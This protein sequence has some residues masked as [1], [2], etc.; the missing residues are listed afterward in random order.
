[1][2]LGI[3][4]PPVSGHIN[5]FAALG[6][7]L[8]RR[9]HRVTWFHMED[10]AERIASEDL[11]FCPIGQ[12][13]HP[14]G[15]LPRSLAQLGRLQGWPALRFTINAIRRT[16]DMI[17]RDL[18]DAV[19]RT[20]IDAL[21]V[22]QTEP[23][24]GSVAEHL[25]MPFLTVCNALALNRDPF[26]PPPFTPWGYSQSGWARVRNAM[27]YAISDR[28]MS[29]VTRVLGGY[30]EQWKLPLLRVGDEACSKLA[31]ISQQ[32]AAFDFPRERLPENF[33]YTGPLR[34]AKPRR[35][36]FPWERLDGRP[37]IFASL[38]T[39][40]NGKEAIFR[41][42]AES[43]AGLP[44]QLVIAHG[45]GL[46][47]KAVAGLAGDP[48]AVPY[49]PQVEVLKKCALTL[50]H[51]GLNT[52]LDS[53]SQGVPA[54]AIP[55]TFEQ[56]AIAARLLWVG[57][58]CRILPGKLEVQSLRRRIGE[59]MEASSYQQAAA[60]V[61]DSIREA[62]GTTRAADIVEQSLK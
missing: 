33:Y 10:L 19:R 6:R 44:V 24:G 51:A 11:D 50:T 7:E 56:P 4:S 28:L 42:F 40:Q 22:D 17:C 9:G 15:S 3:I 18:P 54:I 62:G 29:P 47:Q 43:C 49:A 46:D 52:I 31:Q 23:A 20:G 1:M 55:L 34:D 61:A 53:L 35:N 45:G 32:P 2:R 13:D 5:P 16:T 58:G 12:A 39:L 8:R 14:R 36:E 37:L 48:I 27:G 30:R 25:G 38:G 59:V 26:V 21:L 60:R 41:C 57:A